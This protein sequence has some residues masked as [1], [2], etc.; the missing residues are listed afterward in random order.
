MMIELWIAKC[1]PENLRTQEEKYVSDIK[2]QEMRTRQA[3]ADVLKRARV[4]I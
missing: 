4:A 3:V 1:E 2:N